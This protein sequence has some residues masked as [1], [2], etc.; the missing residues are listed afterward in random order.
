M[1]TDYELR[2]IKSR[3]KT[4]ALQVKDDRTVIVKAPYRVSM[5]FIRSFAS[6]HER[7]IQKRLSEMKERIENAGEPLSRE[8]LSE[9]YRRA[10]AHIPGRVGYYA[11]RLGVS[12]GRIT[13]R[14][15]RTRWGSCSSK[16]NLNFN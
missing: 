5:S 13:I 6:S 16:G 12:Y 8:E 15:Q 11:E 14:K 4:I 10:R 9:L 2:I 7:W 3:R 1:N